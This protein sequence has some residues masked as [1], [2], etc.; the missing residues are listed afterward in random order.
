MSTS[1]DEYCRRNNPE[2]LYTSF[3]RGSCLAVALRR[4]GKVH[5]PP[6]NTQHARNTHRSRSNR[7]ENAALSWKI[8]AE[9]L[10]GKLSN[11]SE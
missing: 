8:R 6:T 11:G 9:I 4:C 7:G 2:C 3:V 10:E 1:D 5:L